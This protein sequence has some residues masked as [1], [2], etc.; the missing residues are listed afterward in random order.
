MAAP[1]FEWF[2]S[3]GFATSITVCGI[4]KGKLKAGSSPP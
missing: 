3:M 4:Y 1:L 2:Y